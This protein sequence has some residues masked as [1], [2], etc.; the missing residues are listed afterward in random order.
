[1]AT[2]FFSPRFMTS[3][4]EILAG[5]PFWRGTA[6]T[7]A[8]FAYEYGKYAAGVVSMAKLAQLAGA[9][10]NMDPTSSDFMKAR[11]GTLRVDLMSGLQQPLVLAARLWTGKST[12]PHKPDQEEPKVS[13]L[14]APKYGGPTRATVAVKY[15]QSKAAPI[16]GAIWAWA[17]TKNIIGEPF[18]IKE[19]GK[20]LVTPM[21][22]REVMETLAKEGVE[23]AVAAGILNFLGLGTQSHAE[24][25]VEESPKSEPE[26][27]S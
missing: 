23:K 12:G 15:G 18:D 26:D 19:T 8:Q 7:R 27:G 10:V 14:T 3:R 25:K 20:D 1:M 5:Q 21:I 17:D 13:D 11:F 2:L 6:K 16:P 4:A 9:E 24:K 22:A